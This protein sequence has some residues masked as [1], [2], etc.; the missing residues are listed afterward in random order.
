MRFV[1]V[2]VYKTKKPATGYLFSTCSFPIMN[3]AGEGKSLCIAFSAH[4]VLVPSTGDVLCRNC[5]FHTPDSDTTIS[6]CAYKNKYRGWF[7]SICYQPKV[8]LFS[9]LTQSPRASW[10]TFSEKLRSIEMK[11]RPDKYGSGEDSRDSGVSSISQKGRP[12]G[13][14]A[15][16]VTYQFTMLPCSGTTEKHV[17]NQNRHLR[18][19][20]VG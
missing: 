10:V 12:M 6:K 5:Q 3:N 20:A 2:N 17:K 1:F 19:Y 14:G 7:K 18:K 15:R 9:S 4:T 13:G 16:I 8:L 11:Y